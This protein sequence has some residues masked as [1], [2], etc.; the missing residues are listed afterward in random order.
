MTR[1]ALLSQFN[2]DRMN[3]FKNVFIFAFTQDVRLILVAHFTALF[4][5]GALSGC[6]VGSVKH[7]FR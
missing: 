7:V 6:V 1:I 5:P 4:H 2:F 3:L